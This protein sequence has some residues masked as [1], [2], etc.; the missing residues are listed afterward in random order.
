YDLEMGRYMQPDPLGLVDDAALYNYARQSP[1]M[2]VD[3]RGENP[4]VVQGIRAFLQWLIGAGSSATAGAGAGAMAGAGTGIGIGIG[5]GAAI[6]PNSAG[7]DGDRPNSVPREG[8]MCEDPCEKARQ[9]VRDAKAQQKRINGTSLCV[10]GGSTPVLYSK[11]RK[12]QE[13][14]NARRERDRVCHSDTNP[15]PVT[16]YFEQVR[17][18]QNATNCARQLMGRY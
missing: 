11:F 5:I 15:S 7:R 4:I 14:C 13:E 2:Y 16:E 12:W 18:C 9:R 8:E 10:P 17:A 3:P 1:M 6:T